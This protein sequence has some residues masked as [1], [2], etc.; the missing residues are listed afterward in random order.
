MMGHLPTPSELE[1]ILAWQKAHVFDGGSVRMEP[2]QRPLPAYKAAGR[3]EPSVLDPTWKP[4]PEATT[5]YIAD[6]WECESR[7]EARRVLRQ[8]ELERL[9]H[10]AEAVL[11]V[12]PDMSLVS[13][14]ALGNIIEIGRAK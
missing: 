7:G 8:Q 14:A 4:S 2:I 9:A 5:G 10:I 3:P 1:A 6:H 13:K 12:R 11:A